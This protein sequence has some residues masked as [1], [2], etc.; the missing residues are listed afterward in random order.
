V[1]AVLLAGGLGTR[2]SEETQITPKPMIDIGGRPILWH[3]MKGYAVHGVRHFVVAL[4][5]RGEAIRNF[6][7]HELALAGANVTVHTRT[8]DVQVDRSAHDDWVVDLVETGA[9]TNTGG[10]LARLADWLPDDDFC[11]TYGDGVCDVDISRLIDFH[12]EQ[13]RQ[14]TI[15]AVR[16]PARFGGLV[17]DGDAVQEFTEKPQIGE[18]WINGGFMVFRRDV[19]G[20]LAGDGDSLERD[21]LEPLAEKGEL[22]AYRHE[23]YWQCMDTLREVRLLREQWDS[24]VPAWKTWA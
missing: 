8:G 18:G 13:G 9:A 24:G 12:H 7:V 10:R 19:L 17:L 5:Y 4:G 16:P 22:A 15:T 11:L 14:A 21:L 3:I 23:N 20:Q 1:R 2:L 6:F